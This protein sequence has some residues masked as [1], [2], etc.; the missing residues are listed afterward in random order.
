MKFSNMKGPRTTMNV[1]E[2]K[3]KEKKKTQKK[4]TSNPRSQYSMTMIQMHDAKERKKNNSK[5]K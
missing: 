4:K 1:L 3:R 2:D 5:K